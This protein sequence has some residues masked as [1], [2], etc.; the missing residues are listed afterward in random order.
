MKKNAYMKLQ[1]K[2]YIYFISFIVLFSTTIYVLNFTLIRKVL[3]DIAREEIK[4]KVESIYLG[5]ELQLNTAV[6][7]YLRGITEGQITAI[8][9][10]YNKQKR[11]N[12]TERQAKDAVQRFSIHQ[13]VGDSGYIV[14]VKK[15]KKQIFLEMHPFL[16]W[17]DCTTN[18]G[19]QN[20]VVQ[21]NGYNEYTWK[22][23][24]DQKI[25]EKVAYIRYFKPWDWVVGATSYKDEFV[26]LIQ[27]EK[28]KQVIKPI[29]FK[30]TGYCFIYDSSFNMLI[31]PELE[32]INVAKIKNEDGILISTLLS[33]ANKNFKKYRWKNPS[34]K[35]SREKYVYVRK[36][37]NF[38]WYLAA[39]VYVDEVNQPVKQLELL[40]FFIL[41]V[42]SILLAV[43]GII[44]N[45]SLTKPL[46]HILK[47]I[48]LFYKDKIPFKM[49][50]KSVDEIMELGNA[51]DEL[52]H[53]LSQSMDELHQKIN[54]LD[55][56]RDEKKNALHFL[57]NII[58]S[59]PS[60]L[61][62]VNTDKRIIMW[63]N[64][65]EDHTDVKSD[66]AVTQ[67]LIK[68][69]P[70]FE[71]IIYLI[72]ESIHDQEVKTIHGL[73]Y[74]HDGTVHYEEV[75]IYPL[76]T[77]GTQGAVLRVD[78]VTERIKMEEVIQ[79]SR[80]MDAIGHL[81]G[82]IAHD[83]NNMLAGIMS[84][85]QI[86][87]IKLKEDHPSK[88]YVNIIKE[89][90]TRAAELTSKLLNFS[91][92]SNI[93]LAPLHLHDAIEKIIELLG[94][95]IDKKIKIE[96]EL[97]AETDIVTG[98]NAQLQNIFLNL[99]I[100]SAHAQPDGGSIKYSTSMI[101]ITDS[102]SKINKFN[103]SPGKYIHVEVEDEGSGIPED[104]IDKIYDPFFTTKDP[105]QGTGLGL[106]SVYGI[107]EQ[108][109]GAISVYSEV[110]HGT[111]FSIYLPISEENVN[112]KDDILI[113]PGNGTILVIDDEDVVRITA[114]ELLLEI[115]Y[116]VLLAKDGHEGITVYKEHIEE[117][118][119]VL[120]DMIM[121]VMNGREC[122]TRLK[123][124]NENIKVVFSSGFSKDEDIEAVKLMGAKGFIS[125]P[126][127]IGNLSHVI[128]KTMDSK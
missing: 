75:T 124:I 122:F 112:T 39:S 100:N 38:N 30:K 83:F 29:R 81:S 103:I 91:R 52:T 13:K 73:N 106:A 120:M 3:Q 56:S 116:T 21:K 111:K 1:N 57:D 15:I 4:E 14:A 95:S 20:W 74:I 105:G 44:F 99:G 7:N 79:Q 65:A 96:K 86:L 93:D 113:V 6:E 82:G 87:D 108:H 37:K 59:M 41:V 32:G 27:L 76:V 110:N 61:I 67:K 33:S 25:R 11:G 84:A 66:E 98:D 23:P 26:K 64:K 94:R 72:E 51:F 71:D 126:Y 49:K 89:A 54:E 46:L 101:N 70:R 43:I 90:A 58:N 97:M 9:Q 18:K 19:C 28:L 2:I 60:L 78:D 125:K 77:S 55:I 128:K 118:D 36:L 45:K 62:G 80:K 63:N 117:I 107:I 5:V 104:I 17:K 12:L 121:P 123:E 31:H 69:F 127:D 47:G 16:R 114:N 53:K 8:K 68:L 34:E 115:G 10:Y 85:A 109:K 35:K 48:H 102:F 88:K 40:I 50:L 42:S 22:N 119:I 24:K 92:K